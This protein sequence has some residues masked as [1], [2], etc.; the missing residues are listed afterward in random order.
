MR[1]PVSGLS[2]ALG[3]LLGCLGLILLIRA[4]LQHGSVLP[5]VAVVI[6]GMSLIGLFASSTLYHLLKVSHANIRRLRTLDHMMIFVF[7]A[8]S[9]TPLCLVT[10]RGV[11]GWS[12]LILVWMVAF[13]GI[14]M[15]IFWMDA[16]RWLYTLL[17]VIMGWLSVAVIYPLTQS[18]AAVGVCWLVVGGLFFTVGAVIYGTKWPDPFPKVFGFHEIWHIFVLLGSLAHFWTIYRYVV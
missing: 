11:V 2:H 3:V 17:Y 4:G 16:P 14:V 7:I 18:L 9:Y 8:G 13:S 15:K 5:L 10:L 6:Y 12:L 1:E